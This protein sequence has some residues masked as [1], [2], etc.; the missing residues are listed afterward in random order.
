V[1]FPYTS[2]SSI[3]SQQ[4]AAYRF[5]LLIRIDRLLL[6]VTLVRD[7]ESVTFSTHSALIRRTFGAGNHVLLIKA[8]TTSGFIRPNVN[9]SNI[10]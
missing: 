8:A 1:E 7:T 3:K 10:S 2:K 5:I 6:S 4:P 9:L